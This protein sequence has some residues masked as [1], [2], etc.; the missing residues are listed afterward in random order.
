MNSFD[1]SSLPS[2]TGLPRDTRTSDDDDHH[3]PPPPTPQAD[4]PDAACARFGGPG[5]VESRRVQSA[6]ADPLLPLHACVSLAGFHNCDS[7]QLG[8]PALWWIFSIRA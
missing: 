6:S 2:T 7:R 3:H 5:V 8:A 1:L 4:C